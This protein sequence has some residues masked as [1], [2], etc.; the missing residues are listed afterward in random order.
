MHKFS[1][2]PRRFDAWLCTG[3]GR[4]ARACPA[5]MDLPEILGTLVRLSAPAEWEGGR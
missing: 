4:C 2:Y 5:G 3:C 1:I